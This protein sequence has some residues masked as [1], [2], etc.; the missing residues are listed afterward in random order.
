MKRITIKELAQLSSVSTK[1]VSK[2][3]NDQPGV[4]KDLRKKIKKL[5]QKKNYIPN[6]FG[7]GLKGNSVKTVGV[8][9]TSSY[10][11]NF[12]DV[13]SGIGEIADESGYSII[14]C[15][16]NEDIN[17]E[18]KQIELLIQKQVDGIIL[19][20]A[21]DSIDAKRAGI[22]K[23]KKLEVP[24][25]LIYRGI[26]GEEKNCVRSDNILGG[27]LATKYLIDK[28]HRNILY[29]TPY[30]TAEKINSASQ[31]RF[32]GYKKALEEINIKALDNNIYQCKNISL[33]SGYEGM[34]TI[35]R[36]RRDFTAVF[37]FND[38]IAFGA[39]KAMH[40]CGLKIPSDIAVIGFDNMLFSQVCLVPLTTVHQESYKIG[41]TAME[42]VLKKINN[43]NNFGKTQMI[44]T[45]RIIER[46][47]A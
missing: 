32:L 30:L 21:S 8:I 45:P 33:D 31:D 36:E 4:N 44:F 9:V 39:V 2:A 12:A 25:I 1:T 16:S 18:N 35:L 20:P 19:T 42:I 7:R 24:Y 11:P 26:K 34:V 15:N 14:L 46:L 3:L 47:S 27:Y 38:I 5:A 29:L 6:L 28:R 41:Y 17:S 10:N 22:E 37:C 23:L 43:D 40:E 13:I